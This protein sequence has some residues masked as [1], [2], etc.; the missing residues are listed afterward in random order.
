MSMVLPMVLVDFFG[1][2]SRS[3]TMRFHEVTVCHQSFTLPKGEVG[4]PVAVATF[5]STK[6]CGFGAAAS[7]PPT[8]T[9]LH[10]TSNPSML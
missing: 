2:H 5:R 8:A 9:S 4:L 1:K 10:K 7:P 3:G 6:P